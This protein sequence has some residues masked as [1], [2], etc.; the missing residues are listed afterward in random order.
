MR[1]INKNVRWEIFRKNFMNSEDVFQCL[2]CIL[3]SYHSITAPNDVT[4]RTDDTH[5]GVW[6]GILF[7]SSKIT[8]AAGC[9]ECRFLWKKNSQDLNGKFQ[10]IFHPD[11]S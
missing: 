1:K 11:V 10:E 6:R 2:I 5:C 4:G 7:G 9:H 3:I 8:P